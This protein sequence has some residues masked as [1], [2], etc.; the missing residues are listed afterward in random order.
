M[1][2]AFGKTL[3]FTSKYPVAGRYKAPRTAGH[4]NMNLNQNDEDRL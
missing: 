2:K 4:Q 3:L 1:L